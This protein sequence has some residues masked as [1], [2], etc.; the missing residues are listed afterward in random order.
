MELVIPLE[1][2]HDE[3]FRENK[4]IDKFI[5]NIFSYKVEFKKKLDKISCWS[6]LIKMKNTELLADNLSHSC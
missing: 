6:N 3:K 2:L 4:V 1:G 5:E